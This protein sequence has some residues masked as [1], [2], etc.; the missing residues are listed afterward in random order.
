M[1]SVIAYIAAIAVVI[2]MG[3]ILKIKADEAENLKR[4]IHALRE[5]AIREHM[6]AKACGGQLI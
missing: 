3:G 6:R 1:K 2:F 5:A 4:E